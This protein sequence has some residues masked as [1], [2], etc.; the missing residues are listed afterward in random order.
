LSH[1]HFPS[2]YDTLNLNKNLKSRACLKSQQ[3]ADIGEFWIYTRHFY[4]GLPG[5]SQGK[6]TQ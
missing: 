4:A 2:K 1:G 3:G 6:V 5:V